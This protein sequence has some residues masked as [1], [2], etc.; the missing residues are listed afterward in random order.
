MIYF[1]VYQV[2]IHVRVLKHHI[3]VSKTH[4]ILLATCNNKTYHMKTF[5]H[6]ENSVTDGI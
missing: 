6:C 2:Q 5:R 3:R 4:S 1:R